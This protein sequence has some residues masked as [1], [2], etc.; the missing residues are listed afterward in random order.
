MMFFLVFFF[1]WFKKKNYGIFFNIY[2]LFLNLSKIGV[3]IYKFEIR[4]ENVVK[5]IV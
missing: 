4:G 2:I 5:G 1:K 3:L